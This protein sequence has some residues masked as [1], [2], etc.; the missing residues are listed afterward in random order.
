[1]G[2]AVGYA[3]TRSDAETFI[4]LLALG[5]GFALPV[6]LLAATGAPTLETATGHSN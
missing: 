3:L 1:M 6:Y 4:V 2:A 5:A